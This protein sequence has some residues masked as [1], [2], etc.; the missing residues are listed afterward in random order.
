M[1]DPTK[2][3]LAAVRLPVIPADAADILVPTFTEVPVVI[4]PTKLILAAVRLPVT[5]VAPPTLTLPVMPAPPDTCNAPVVVLVLAAPPL[6][7]SIFAYS[8]DNSTKLLLN[9]T[10]PVTIS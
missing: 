10:L 4:D 8:V 9:T 1:I 6:A 3:I 2:L 7:M 5:A